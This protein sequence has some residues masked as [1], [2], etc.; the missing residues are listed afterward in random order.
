VLSRE[1]AWDAQ[2]TEVGADGSFAFEGLPTELYSLS[3]RIPGY[4][5]SPENGSYD[6]LNRVGLLGRLDGNVQ[7]L[8]LIFDPGLETR[9][10]PKFD[11]GLFERYE[12]LRKA[13]LRGVEMEAKSELR[14]R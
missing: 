3:S 7:D 13:P 11:K 14:R 9:E 5:L 12:A 6:F 4:V 10:S 8:V 2:T 1:E